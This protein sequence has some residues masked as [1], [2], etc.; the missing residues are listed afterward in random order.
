MVFLEKY[1]TGAPNSTG[2]YELDYTLANDFDHAWRT[3]HVSSDVFVSLHGVSVLVVANGPSVLR[4]LCFLIV[5][6]VSCPWEDG[7]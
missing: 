3:M 4:A 1:G 5:L 6:A 2:A 7:H